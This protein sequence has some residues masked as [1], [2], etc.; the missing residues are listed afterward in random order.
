M[1]DRA[2]PPPSAAAAV[3]V[4]WSKAMDA[5]A[6]RPAADQERIRRLAARF[7]DQA[8]RCITAT[9]EGHREQLLESSASVM[10]AL[11]ALWVACGLAPQEIWTELYKRE[12]L[13]SLLMQLN[14]APGQ[15]PRRLLKPWRVDSTKLP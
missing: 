4:L 7:S 9:L 6:T 8:L 3:S 11:I 10:E 14:Q 5:A 12:Q 1:T 13:G 15:T 2:L